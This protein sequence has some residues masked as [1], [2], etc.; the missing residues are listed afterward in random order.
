[1]REHVAYPADRK[2][3]RQG[4]TS[5]GAPSLTVS[6]SLASPTANSSPSAPSNP[7]SLVVERANGFLFGLRLERR[8]AQHAG[9]HEFLADLVQGGT[10]DGNLV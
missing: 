8:V 2:A 10:H 3:R 1:M 9:R 7:R 4:A 5:D 6:R